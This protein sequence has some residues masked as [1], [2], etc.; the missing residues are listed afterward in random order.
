MKATVLGLGVV[1]PGAQDAVALRSALAGPN[2]TALRISTIPE[3]DPKERRLPRLERIALAAAR[4]ALPPDSDRRSLAAVYATGYGGLTSTVEFLEGIASR[5]PEFGSPTAFYQSVHHSPAGQLSIALGL[6][7]PSL[8]LSARELSG[9]TALRTALTLLQTRRADRVLLV[10]A[11]ER[12]PSL[13]NGYRAFGVLAGEGADHPERCLEPGE[14]GGALLLGNEPGPLQIDECTL[15]GHPCPVLQFAR[16]EQF[17]P[18]IRKAIA[19]ETEPLSFSLAAPNAEISD[20]ESSILRVVPRLERWSDGRHFGFHGSAGLLRL[21]A[22]A[23][24]LRDGPAGA[25]SIVHGLALGGGQA[26]T[27]MRHVAG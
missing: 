24:R 13:D 22:A 5:G 1:A 9:E 19:I 8:T 25:A 23:V 10:A 21:I 17:A 2:P 20:A 16:P 12:S 14:G 6:R 27:V 7:G 3:G 4:Q 26:V 15:T 18:L 11:D